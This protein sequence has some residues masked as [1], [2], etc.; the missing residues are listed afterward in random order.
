MI[1]RNKDCFSLS[2][3]QFPTS[4]IVFFCLFTVLY[5]SFLQVVL[6]YSLFYPIKSQV[7][8][9]SGLVVGE[10]ML[11]I[12]DILCVF[13]L[14]DIFYIVN[15][16]GNFYVRLLSLVQCSHFHFLTLMFRCT[17]P[18]KNTIRSTLR[19]HLRRFVLDLAVLLPKMTTS[20]YLFSFL[21]SLVNR[22]PYRKHFA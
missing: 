4:F 16:K 7:A 13:E 3:Y 21:F 10:E 6:L 19:A 14:N 11:S 20:M 8:N 18:S 2:I 15:S 17:F 9:I 12:G 5:L 22:F 1:W